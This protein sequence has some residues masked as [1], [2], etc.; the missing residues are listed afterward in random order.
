MKKKRIPGLTLIEWYLVFLLALLAA[1]V[2]GC[3]EPQM[4][5]EKPEAV[6]VL[7][8]SASWC[9]PCKRAEPAIEAMA[10][11]GADVRRIDIDAKPVTARQWRVSSVPTLILLR[12]GREVARSHD[13]AAIGR[14]LRS[15][16]REQ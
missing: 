13:P 1:V 10:A 4:R 3:T 5:H 2:I 8:F 12:G 16:A 9:G 14:L 11:A 6:C 7:A 15:P